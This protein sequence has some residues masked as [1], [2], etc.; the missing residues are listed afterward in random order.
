MNYSDSVDEGRQNACILV[1]V[2][3]CTK[4]TVNEQIACKYYTAV[5]LQN[6]RCM[7]TSGWKFGYPV[8]RCKEAC[9]EALN[10][11]I[12]RAKEL[13]DENSKKV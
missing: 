2:Y 5:G 12:R 13:Q 8:C 1:M 9:I 10:T 6:K 11:L 4:L 7:H 3:N